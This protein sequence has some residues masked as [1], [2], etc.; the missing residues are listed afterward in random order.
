MVDEAVEQVR[1][2]QFGQ[3]MALRSDPMAVH[4]RVKAAEDVGQRFKA[5]L[6]GL[7]D[8]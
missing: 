5:Q 3:F 7:T 2:Q 4:A 6:R 1:Q 8:G